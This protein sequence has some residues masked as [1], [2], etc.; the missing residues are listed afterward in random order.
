LR[1]I[2]V[3]RADGAPHPRTS[4]ASTEMA[5]TTLSSKYA[6]EV[7][8]THRHPF[9]EVFNR[10]FRFEMLHNPDLQL[11]DRYIS[12]PVWRAKRLPVA[13]HLTVART[14]G[15]LAASCAMPAAAILLYPAVVVE[16]FLTDTARYADIDSIAGHDADRTPRSA[17]RVRSSVCGLERAGGAVPRRV[18]AGDRDFPATGANHG[19][20]HAGL[21]R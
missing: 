6:F 16:H 19:P 21:V 7:S 1:P 20:R 3:A 17:D 14:T 9:W 10:Q 13:V 11:P 12:E 18:T 8:H 5:S 4:E 15:S 2:S